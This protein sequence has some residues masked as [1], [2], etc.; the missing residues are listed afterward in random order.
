[1]P[2]TFYESAN[3]TLKL[4]EATGAYV[5][6][7]EGAGVSVDEFNEKLASCATEQEKQDLLF[8]TAQ[9]VLGGAGDA[10]R[11]AAGEI[12]AYNEAQAKMNDAMASVG[13][14]MQPILTDLQTLGAEILVQLQPYIQQFAEKYMPT[15]KEA[16]SGLGTT[17]GEII[18]FIADN[19]E[20]ISNIAVIVGAIAVAISLV[21]TALG[22]YN[23]V[24]AVAAVV[25][26]PITGI[27]LAITA[28][29]ALL[30]AGVILA[31]K[32]WDEIKEAVG[33]AVEKIK[34]VVANM[35]D[36]VVGFFSNL[37]NNITTTVGNI[38]ESV[39]N[40]FN[41]I[42]TGI[43]NIIN[44]V[45]ST[46]SNIFNTIKSTITNT[47]TSAKNTV[48][49]IFDRIRQGISDKI[50]AAKNTVKSVIDAI[51]G[52]F[53]FKFS[54]PSIPMPHFGISPSGWKIG[55][56]LKG[57]IPK[58]SI[59]WYENGG[60]FD[61]PTLFGYGNG[62]LGGLGESGAEAVVPLEK[63]TKWLDKIAERLAGKTGSTPIVLQVDGKT[64]AQIS[65]D[66]INDLTRQ[67]GSIPLKLV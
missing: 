21:S 36:A 52:F 46:V 32:Y 11:E 44:G 1:M 61:K 63:N 13:E 29:I 47:I 2:E 41:E 33:K 51:K 5:Q 49:N 57:S 31:I 8:Q 53:N 9:G 10:Y 37:W 17:I 24:M 38:K 65:C 18:T 40:K 35:V 56:L 15:I 43:T 16:L 45:K 19:W 27:I 67:R 66:S 48:L 6:M 25:S 3:E 7:L 30:V 20:M 34:E 50:T 60:I 42:K 62:M 26:A 28:A 12:I 14:T 4:G 54:W 39:V 59:S 22:V 58:L 64:F 23:T 55:D